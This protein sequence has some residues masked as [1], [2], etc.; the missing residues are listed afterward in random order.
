MSYMAL[1]PCRSREMEIA[2]QHIGKDEA[3]QEEQKYNKIKAAKAEA[4]K[5]KIKERNRR[6][7]KK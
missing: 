5:R 2:N 1:L 3:K 4:E 7:Y 6:I